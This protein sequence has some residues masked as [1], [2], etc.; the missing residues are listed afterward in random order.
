MAEPDLF[1]GEPTAP[2]ISQTT[3]ATAPLAERLRP[4]SLG[5]VVGQDAAL[6]ADS[7]LGR[8]LAAGKLGSLILWGPPGC[9]KTTM[10]RLLAKAV[11]E[12]L[13]PLSAV[14]SG[15]AELRKAFEAARKLA[16]SGRRPVLFID[17]I[18]RYNRAQQDGLLHEVE[19]G[20][21]SLI[22]ATTENPSFA[23]NPALISRCHVVVLERLDAAALGQLVSRAETAL[24][25]ALPLT[26]PARERLLE[27]ADGDGRY[28]LNMVE[29]LADLPPES[30][31]GPG[32]DVE[33]LAQVLQR[34]LPVYD[35]QQE[36]HYNL[37]S[38]LH[39]AVRGSDP[40]AA[41]YWLC[42]MLD[43]GEDPRYLARRLIRMANEDIGLAQPEAMVQAVS[44]AQVYERLGS[45][46][47][48]LALAQ[49]AVHL[50]LAPKSNAVYKAYADARR[51][52]REHGSLMPPAHILNA[53]TRLMKDLGYGKG[54]DYDHDA[55][56]RFSGQS[57]FPDGMA[58]QR[59]YQPTEE[60][61]E[62]RLK[63]RGEWLEHLRVERQTRDEQS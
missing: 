11:G 9:G 32:L 59:F 1:A 16:Q 35:K 15:V 43:A 21:V 2:M 6:A 61:L 28:L 55:P 13:L 50:A 60:G 37:I 36:A 25:H 18:H 57:Y 52:A 30:E 34:R 40:D 47:G 24:G 29:S 4:G 27:L 26:R 14:M 63:E 53:P 38:A 62:K 31:L 45:P 58:R 3:K 39:K 17:E 10:A 22:G 46:E 51:S 19:A 23:L 41:L 54:Y 44:A 7:P 8:M 42:R 12:Q 20:T 56:D 33:A 49:V 5:E 48:E